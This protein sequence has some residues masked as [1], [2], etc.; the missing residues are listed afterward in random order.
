MTRWS[1]RIGALVCALM[2]PAATAHAQG[3]SST[4][5]GQIVDS[6]GRTPLVG[7]EVDVTAGQRS[8]SAR[9]NLSGHYAVSGLPAGSV[10]VR[11]RLLGYR[12]EQRVV[13]L[14]ADEV[15]T[16][17]FA[18]VQEATLLDQIVTTGTPGETQVRAIGNVVATISASKVMETSPA[19]SVSSLIG[20]GTPGV[21]M[22]PA[23]GQ[24]GTGSQVRIRGVSSMSLT[25]NPI[26]YIDGVR[27]DANSSQG[28]GERG[29]L[30]VS[31]LD[32]INP[33]DIASIQ[34]IEGP[35]AGTLYGTEAS[36]GVIQ[37]I[38]KRGTSGKPKWS[39]STRQGAN[40]LQ[41][42]EGR[43]GFLFAKNASGGLDSVNL[44]QH[45]VQFGNGPI[46]RTGK[47]RG[48]NLALSGGTDAARYYTAL[49]SD[50][51]QGA[52]PWN[53]S[54]KMGLRAN[55]D[56]LVSDELKIQ[57]SFGYLQNRT[58]LAQEAIGVDPFSSLIWGNP[59]TLNLGQR[60][61]YNAP[62]EEWSTVQAR[63]DADRTTT[64]ITTEYRPFN[65]LTN[66]LIAGVDVTA[67][68][69]WTLYPLQ[70]KGSLDYL[71]SAGLGSKSVQRLL[72]NYVTLDYS[73]SARYRRGENLLFT[74]SV[75]LQYYHQDVSAITATGTN[76]PA[77]PITTVSG[78]ATRN[79]TETYAANATVG[80]Y[81]QEE[82]A[83]QNRLF[84]TAALREDDNS[85]FGSTFKAAY[86][87]KVSAS[88]VV[89]EEP[90][91]HVGW[92]SGLRL[93]AA[94]GASGTQPGTFDA[95][96]LYSPAVGYQNQPALVPSS[97][98][99]PALKPER[100]Q[101]LETGFEGTLFD[102]FD[103]VYTHYQRN[104]TDAIV[105]D[106]LPPSTGFPGSQVVNIGKVSGW[107]DA[108]SL[109]TRVL[110]TH[111]VR[112]DFGT[113]YA[114]NG[115][116]IIDMGGIPFI[117]VAGGQAQN[118]VGF[119]IGDIFMYKI[120]SATIDG[121]GKVLTMTC[122]GGTGRDGLMQGGP[123]VP[124][125]SAPRV[126]WGPS[127]PT[128]QLGFNTSVTLWN[129]LTLFARVDGTGNNYTADTEVRALHNLGLTK[130]INLRNDPLLQA[131]RS[132]ENDATGTYNAGYLRLS[133]ISATYTL[134]RRVLARLLNASTASIQ[135][136][137]SNVSMLWTGQ[138]GWN[139]ARDGEVYM[140]FGGT[141]IWDPSIRGAGDLSS[142]YQT[143]LPPAANFTATMRVTF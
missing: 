77:I 133:Q 18:L 109:N 23:S 42:P 28:P 41:N 116:R 33:N 7:V 134:P 6:V 99:N 80:M 142:G 68:N 139:T 72:Q 60:G 102:R 26:I 46:F 88:W 44:Y 4:L 107:G 15:H 115:S 114:Y 30:G 16:L 17:D 54:K 120:R 5:R 9:T 8:F 1:A 63:A 29:G 138:N 122:D 11:T 104:I 43:A 12:P 40:W 117:S 45:E 140:P 128:W 31:R 70:P 13:T 131:Y 35:A 130:A 24:V 118:R 37:I 90:W 127:Q 100:S 67:E 96:Q 48:Y 121:Q 64:S 71:G 62:P 95:Q 65:W 129:D 39:F 136:A 92:V 113:Q 106:P 51:D 56:L 91:F 79:G 98:G 14:A 103:I 84:F 2:L 38:T 137:M 34:V 27:M 93:R 78:G 82:V 132:I 36:N 124:C 69:N 110:E 81:G 58:R 105:N 101:E 135:L 74:T 89:S 49:S 143:I 55:L 22:L 52:I 87:P 57:T 19:L 61:F 75:G 97:F 111:T 20:S 21:I 32:D 125:A 108:L 47:A 59:R 76:F 66:R 10:R 141:H 119:G 85:A 86:Y 126:R 3:A 112:W 123:D 94:L 25:N 83:W 73:G 53:W 50:D